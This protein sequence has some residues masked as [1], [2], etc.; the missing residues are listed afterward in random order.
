MLNT[1][2]KKME[3]PADRVPINI[4]KYGNTSMSSIPLLLA[5]DFSDRLRGSTPQNLLLAAFGIGY[6]WA[7]VAITVSDIVTAKVINS[8]VRA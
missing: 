2:V 6:S 5:D 7:A 4:G 1:L 3:L 8:K